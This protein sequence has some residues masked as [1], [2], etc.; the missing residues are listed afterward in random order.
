MGSTVIV[1]REDGRLWMHGMAKANHTL[2][3][4]RLNE[5][6]D[7]FIQLHKSDQYDRKEMEEKA[8]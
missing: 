6:T 4:D 8:V 3:A 2:A 5:P 1:Q 7:H